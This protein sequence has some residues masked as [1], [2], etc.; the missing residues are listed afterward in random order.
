MSSTTNTRMA[1]LRA[2]IRNKWGIQQIETGGSI[3]GLQYHVGT[4]QTGPAAPPPAPGWHTCVSV[5][6]CDGAA[7]RNRWEIKRIERGGE[8]KPYAALGWDTADRPTSWTSQPIPRAA[9]YLWVRQHD[10]S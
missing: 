2:A 1:Y 7:I 9:A 6:V 5:M 8:Y 10:V 4:Q 3:R